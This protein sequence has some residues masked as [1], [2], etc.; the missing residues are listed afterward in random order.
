MQFS[1]NQERNISINIFFIYILYYIF[2]LYI[3]ALSKIYCQVMKLRPYMIVFVLVCLQITQTNAQSMSTMGRDFWLSFMLGRDEAAMSVT[4]T[5][6]RAC[7]GTI[8]NPNTGWTHNFS[9]PAGGSVTVGIDTANSYNTVSNAIANKGLHVTTTDTVSV[10][11]SNYLRTSFD[12]TYILPTEALG[13]EYM[14]QTFETWRTLSPSEILV[15][16]TEDN[17]IVD[18]VPTA[19][20][21]GRTTAGGFNITLDAGQSYLMKC[22]GTGDYSGTRIKSR[23]CKPI[24]VFNGHLCA[25]I[26]VVTGAYCDHLFEQSIPVEYWGRRFVATM[27]SHHNGDYIKITSLKDSCSVSVG[28][29]YVTTIN[30]GESYEFTLTGSN[31]SKYIETSQ[32]ATVY[33]YLV[34]KNS[35]NPDGDPS[36]T[37]VAPIEQQLKDVVFVNYNNVDQLT[38]YHYLNVVA[39]TADVSQIYLDGVSLWNSFNPVSGNSAYSYARVQTTPGTHRLR[40]LGQNGFI[41][42]VYGVGENESY[43]YSVGFSTRPNIY[44]M[45]VNGSILAQGDTLYNCVGDTLKA[46]I[47]T[48]DTIDIYGWYRNGAYIAEIDTFMFVTNGVGTERIRV[49]YGIER[50]CYSMNDSIWF[51]MVTDAPDSSSFDTLICDGVFVWNGTTYNSSGV[52]TRTFESA[53]RCDSIVELTLHIRQSTTTFFDSNVC[54]SIFVNGKWLYSDTSLVQGIYTN[55]DGCDSIVKTNIVIHPSYFNDVFVNLRYGDTL[56]WLDYRQYADTNF[57]PVYSLKSVWGCDSTVRLNINLI[58]PPPPPPIDSSAIWVPNAFT[59]DENNNTVFRIFCNDI[60][61]AQVYVYNRWGDYVTDFDGLTGCWDGRKDG[62]PCKTDS[63]V[64]II[65]YRIKTMPKILKKKTGIVTL[66][67]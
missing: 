14:V 13:N 56:I 3:F 28:G 18:I 49:N 34:S 17:T 26:P 6:I 42:N 24:A 52:Y 51:Y 36:M 19:S 15:V 22:N 67:R 43:G 16:A 8:T 66:L 29:N 58:Y 41:A 30:A 46:F 33:S 39:H 47:V 32:P 2:F 31:T 61:E 11:A 53:D 54:D 7:T 60:L 25:H 63:Y 38:Q 37:L 4:I 45:N 50:E 44:W 59:P 21:T 40:S 23:D 5:G 64:Y 1:D 62:K 12:V 9:V 48:D 35:S 57:H 20:T 65:N 10:Y 55:Q 27:S